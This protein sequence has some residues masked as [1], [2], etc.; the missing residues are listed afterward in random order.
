[1]LEDDDSMTVATDKQ[2]YREML[3]RHVN[4][5]FVG[6]LTLQFREKH[7]R[8]PYA[9]W[10]NAKDLQCQVGVLR[11]MRLDEPIDYGLIEFLGSRLKPQTLETWLQ[12]V[13]EDAEDDYATLFA[14]NALRG[15]VTHLVYRV[16]K[17]FA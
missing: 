12:G 14:H 10:G 11:L 3:F 15:H 8:F 1:M 17:I 16:G 9:L 6:Q 5:A 7:L 13:R 4:N 2:G